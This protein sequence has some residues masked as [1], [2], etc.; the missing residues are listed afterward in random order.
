MKDREKKAA[1]KKSA[2]DI[3]DENNTAHVEGKQLKFSAA[4][5]HADDFRCVLVVDR[6]HVPRDK[7]GRAVSSKVVRPKHKDKKQFQQTVR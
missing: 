7:K 2:I 6:P 4:K 1:K 3:I 5:S